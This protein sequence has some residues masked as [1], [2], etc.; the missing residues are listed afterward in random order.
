MIDIISAEKAKS[1]TDS[2]ANSER[3]NYLLGRIDTEIRSVAT[4]GECEL[5]FAWIK[6]DIDI[7]LLPKLRETLIDKGYVVSRL[8]QQYSET[9]LL[10]ISW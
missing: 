7:S 4:G 5:L 8:M 1:M 6:R 10:K 9:W 2:N 3:L